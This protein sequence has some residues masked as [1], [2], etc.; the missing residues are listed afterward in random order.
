VW[1]IAPRVVG[2]PH[3][4]PPILIVAEEEPP[5]HSSDSDFEVEDVLSD[6]D[7]ELTPKTQRD[8][9]LILERQKN[10]EEE[11][12][13]TRSATPHPTQRI[14]GVPTSP[15]LLHQYHPV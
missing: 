7:V 5:Q 4:V 1:G 12:G 15:L 8:I 14:R 2:V 3:Q 10:V 6:D 13:K 11:M 9:D